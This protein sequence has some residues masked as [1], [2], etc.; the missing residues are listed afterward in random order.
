MN[1]DAADDAEIFAFALGD[2]AIGDRVGNGLGDGGLGGAKHLNGLA[3]A[4]DRD[5]GDHDGRGL[6]GEIRRDHGEEVGVAFALTGEGI[7]E[8]V[9]DGAIFA[10][11]QEVDMS[12]FVAFTDKAFADVHGHRCI[13]QNVLRGGGF[14][15]REGLEM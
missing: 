13:L 2:D 1:E 15:F 11:D 4:L 7:G 5:L 8:R 12:D 14:C 9:A 6:H 10:A 3:H